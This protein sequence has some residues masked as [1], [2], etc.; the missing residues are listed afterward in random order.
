[1][2]SR[3]ADHRQ[4]DD[5]VAGGAGVLVGHAPALA[6]MPSAHSTAW[7]ASSSAPSSL[8]RICSRPATGIS[9]TGSCQGRRSPRRSACRGN[10]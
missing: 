7:G 10:S 6:R 4:A 8:W 2:Q 1:V 5:A 9:W 3:P